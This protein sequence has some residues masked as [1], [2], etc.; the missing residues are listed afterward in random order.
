MGVW[1][2][3]YVNVVFAWSI[4]GLAIAGYF[5][6][7]S[8]TDE[9]WAFWPLLAAGFAM[10]GVS[11]LLLVLGEP[12]SAWDMPPIRIT[13]YSLVVAALATLIARIRMGG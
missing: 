9:K 3:Y 12:A 2:M 5:K 1:V 4:V 13:G 7:L 10:F 6:T 8:I 11:H